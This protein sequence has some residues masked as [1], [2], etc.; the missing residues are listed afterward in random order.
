MSRMKNAWIVALLLVA[1]CDKKESTTADCCQTQETA[2]ITPRGITRPAGLVLT[3]LPESPDL[4]ACDARGRWGIKTPSIDHSIV[5]PKEKAP[6][7]PAE[8]NP[9]LSFYR[10]SLPF[11]QLNWKSGDW[12]VTQLVFPVGKGFV[13]RYHVMNHGEEARTGQLKVGGSGMTLATAG[14]TPSSSL[15]FDLKVEPG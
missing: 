7:T 3:G 15:A 2:K 8:C 4:V 6:L 11:P 14:Q 13:A 1:G 10:D 12:E 5:D 9:K